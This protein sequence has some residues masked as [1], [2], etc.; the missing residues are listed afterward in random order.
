MQHQFCPRCKF[1]IVNNKRACATCGYKFAAT[2]D[3]KASTTEIKDTNRVSLWGKLLGIASSGS[4]EVVDP[5]QEKP[6]L[7]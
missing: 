1:R 4:K 2:N 6:A 5:A 7:S 3:T